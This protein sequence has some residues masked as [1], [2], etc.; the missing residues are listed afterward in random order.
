MVA[1][2][3]YLFDDETARGWQPF[4]LTRPVGEL[5][6]GAH[7]FRAR[8]ELLF[9]AR[10]AGH[11]SAEHLLGFD[12]PY[13]ARVVPADS[14]RSDQPRLFLSSRAVLDWD[15]R[16]DSRDRAMLLLIAGDVVG[17]FLPAGAPT[18]AAA[19]FVAPSRDGTR[20]EPVDVAGRVLHR[21]WHLVAEN[22]AQILRDHERGH[23]AESEPAAPRFDAIGYSAGALR[24]GHNVTIEPNV[25]MDFSHGPIWLDD[26]VNVRA[27]TRLAGPAYIG[28]GTTLL[29]GPYEAI[30]IGPVC[31]VHGELEES[32]VLG[33]ANK[34]HDGF[35]G[36]AYLGRWVNLGAMTTN[37]DL[38]NNYGTIRMWTPDGDT[39]TGLMKLGCLVG[40]HVKTGIGALLNTGTVIGAGSNLYGTEMP[41]KYV[42]PFSWG[43]GADLVAYDVEKFLDVTQTVMKRRD[44]ALSADMT[45]VLRAAWHLARDSA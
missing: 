27:F 45:R 23:V 37:S 8:A 42:P 12:E 9:G 18:P 4:A 43:T 20:A 15:V 39:D 14:I 6:L 26:G 5:L 19:W 29:G 22:A 10:C 34:S 30:S 3:L 32:I 41:P 28:P 1:L 17:V 16:I 2:T 11:I 21:P 35:L 25:V 38:K 40:D 33:Y 31:R 7:T 24:V 36:H 13:A 44:V